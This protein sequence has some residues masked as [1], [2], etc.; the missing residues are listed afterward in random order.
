[1]KKLLLVGSNT[2]HTYKYL[3]MVAFYFDE[4]LLITDSKREGFSYNSICLDFSLNSKVILKT[5]KKIAQIIRDFEPSLIHI[6]QANSYAYYTLSASK[7]YDIPTVLTTWGSD[8]LLV[9]KKGF[10]LKRMVKYNL[11]KANYLTADSIFVAEEI[12]RLQ[13]AVKEVLI[14]NFGIDVSKLE[15]EKENIIYSNRLHKKLYRIENIIKTFKNFIQKREEENWKL[16]IAGSGEDTDKLKQLIEDLALSAKVDFV[17]WVDKAQNESW[18]SKA[19]IWVSIPESDATS[20]SLL[21]AMYCGCIPI[22]S[23]LPANKEWIV[24]GVNGIIIQ[25]LEEDFFERALLLNESDL[26]KVN[27]ER[28]E[29]DG[30]KEINAKKFIH[31]YDKILKND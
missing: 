10:L 7:N 17:G 21:E 24:D 13:P 3:E 20:I 5:P 1:M 25:N 4:I 19:R 27:F 26:Q 14:A 22:V 9:P 6:H 11:K 15:L 31:L 8:I 18:Y 16:V 30:T 28:I 12:K 2:I 29:Q 23:D